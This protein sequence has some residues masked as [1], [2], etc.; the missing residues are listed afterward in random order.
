MENNM[1][2]SNLSVGTI[3]ETLTEMYVKAIRNRFSFRRLRTVFLW[4]PPGVGKSDGVRQ[5]AEKVEKETG[6]RVVV[7]EANLILFSPV[8]LMGLP[9]AD[10]EHEL[11]VWLRPS[12]FKM[13]PSE[14]VVNILFMDELSAVTPE[15]QKA[16]YQIA[17][18]RKVGEHHFPENCIVIA[19]GNRKTD[20]GMVYRMLH[21]L[22]NRM[23]HF[24]VRPD[25][26]GWKKWATDAGIHPYVIGYL[27]GNIGKLSKENL[28]ADR[29]A[30][31]TPR[32][33]TFVS[34]L[35]HLY[36]SESPDKLFHQIS[37]CIGAG[38]ALEFVSWCKNHMQLP[39][40]EEIFR[41]VA[42]TYPKTPDALYALVLSM[43]AY[44]KEQKEYLTND[45]LENGCKY[46]SRFPADYATM[47]YKEI[48]KIDGM[49]IRLSK[50]SSFKAWMKKTEGAYV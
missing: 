46:V 25:F 17:L 40:T 10:K 21:P 13:D 32:S 5:I 37:G 48:L 42:K 39:D 14:E 22:A 16:A 24:N 4:G 43:T 44:V 26:A 31:P 2:I 34:D 3:V 20:N 18:E 33:W 47:F 29:V 30:F 50:V 23:M 35:L 19:A 9:V 38:T 41:G 1:D 45:R 28:D 11:T 6:K 27:S 15:V 12:I 49:R 7:T 36:G 8:D